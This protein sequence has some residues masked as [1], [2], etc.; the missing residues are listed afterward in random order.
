MN[1]AQKQRALAALGMWH[2]SND[3]SPREY[4]SAELMAALLQELAE[5]PEPEPVAWMVKNGFVCSMIY[6]RK[7]DADNYAADQQKRHDLSGSLASFCVIP[8]YTAPPE[9][10]PVARVTG[11]YGG[12]LSIATVDGRVLP[13]DTA[14]YLAPP[15]P[16]VPDGWRELCRRL[17][18]ELFH[19]DKQ[20]TNTLNDDGEP[21]WQTGKTVRAVLDDAKAALDAAPTPAEAPADVARDA[22]RWRAL[23]QFLEEFQIP[24][25]RLVEKIDAAIAAEKGGA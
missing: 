22:E 6:Q 13:A 10:K 1:E 20:M 5:E 19:C 2:S 4:Q 7:K 9:P 14:L 8:L 15:A 17:Y 18:V 16:S 21:A 11:Y 12:Y 3:D 25:L 23:P 24:Y